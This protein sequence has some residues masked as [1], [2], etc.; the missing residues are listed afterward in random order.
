MF[1]RIIVLILAL[2]AVPPGLAVAQQDSANP[3]E[4]Q[5]PQLEQVALVD[6]LEV[7]RRN[8]DKSYLIDHRVQ[9]TIV[10]GQADLRRID[11]P[12]LLSI[13]RNNDLAAVTKDD[14]VNIV[15]VNMVRQFPLPVLY[16]ADDPIHDEEWVTWIIRTR[17]AP[18]QNIVPIIRPIMPAAGH[19]AAN[20]DS[21]SMLLVDRYGNAKLIAALIEELDAATP[22]RN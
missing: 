15:P 6:V 14:I 13:L 1:F 4:R 10:I 19:F 3:V 17:N 20:P 11:Y 12:Y 21:Q 18:P 8:S 5:R 22:P 7:A 16:E 9:P 2:L